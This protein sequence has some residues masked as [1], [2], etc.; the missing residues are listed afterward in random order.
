[1]KLKIVICFWLAVIVLTALPAFAAP[2]DFDATTE[3]VGRGSGGLITPVNQ[4]VTPAG[5]LVELPDVRPLAL[6]LS[7]DG[8]L[9]VTAG[10]T[11]ELVVLDPA[12]GKIVHR[13]LFPSGKVCPEDAL[14]RILWRAT[15]GARVLYP[16][17]AVK[18][19]AD[20]D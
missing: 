4:I 3:F 2:E 11:R 5:T 17:W 14:N 20:N 19:V 16:A 9:L 12:T 7:P 1:V 18:P 15:K 10:L 8:H 13:V 6:A